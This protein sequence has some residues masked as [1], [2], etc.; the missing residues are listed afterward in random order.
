MS[1]SM[2]SELSKAA[3]IICAYGV[4]SILFILTGNIIIGG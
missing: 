1:D 4:L 3:T 2:K